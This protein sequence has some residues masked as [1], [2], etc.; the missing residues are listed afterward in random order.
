MRRCRNL[1]KPKKAGPG[2]FQPL[3]GASE[4]DVTTWTWQL[5]FE[6]VVGGRAVL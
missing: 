3:V 2:K 4:G 6:V 1:N 5:V